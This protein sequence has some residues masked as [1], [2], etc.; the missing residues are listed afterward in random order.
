MI[1]KF[2]DSTQPSCSTHLS[3]SLDER[4]RGQLMH[5]SETDPNTPRVAR[6]SSSLRVFKQWQLSSANGFQRVPYRLCQQAHF[7]LA[8][9]VPSHCQSPL[10]LLYHRDWHGNPARLRCTV[11]VCDTGEVHQ[12]L[13]SMSRSHSLQCLPGQILPL[14]ALQLLFWPAP[15]WRRCL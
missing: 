12:T 8:A 2:N 10:A 15:C 1:M 7:R 14:K 3:A 4:E 6:G 9:V 13:F 5:A 11:Y